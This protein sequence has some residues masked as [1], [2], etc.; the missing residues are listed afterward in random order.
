[1]KLGIDVFSLRYQ[2]WDAFQL[3]DY[4][5][6]QGLDV[7]HFSDLGPFERLDDGYLYEVKAEADRRSLAL[8]A[9]MLSICPTASNFAEERGTAVEQLREM[10]HIAEILGSPIVRCVLGANADRTGELPLQ[11]HIDATVATCRAV[12]D[13]ALDLGIQIAIEN[14][15]G[16]MLGRELRGLIEQAGPEYV[17]ACIDTGNPLWVGESPFVT[18]QHL[19]PYVLTSHVRDTAAWPHPSGAA[20]QWM[21]MGDGTVGIADWT[22]AFQKACPDVPYSLEIITGSPPRILSY[23]EPSYWEA[24]PDMPAAEFVEFLKLVHAGQPPAV[25]TLTARWEGNPPEY[26]AA[27]RLQ[28]RLDLDRSIRYCQ[29]VLGIGERGRAQP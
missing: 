4:A 1:M 5:Q 6:Q 19:A 23:L 25:P 18:L 26:Q 17:G 12:R 13:Q 16:D 3:L 11:A 29:E 14:H 9:G 22:A 10:L 27:L 15:A 20:V 7:V 8:E 24:Y 2:G 28:Q 21:A